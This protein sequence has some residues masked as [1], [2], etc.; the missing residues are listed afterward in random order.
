MTEEAGHTESL[1]ESLRS[2]AK[3]F[4]ALVQTR[5]EIF[6]SEVDEERTRLA[7]IMVLALTGLFCIGIAVVLFVLLIA[8][9]FW[10]N[11]R[12]LA[13]GVLAVLF[14]FSGLV[15]LL[16]LR[17]EVRQRPKFL[18]ATLAELRKDEKELEVK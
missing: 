7:R 12:L 8:V 15:A 4:I 14:A 1:L 6:A 10:E 16:V 18:A 2:L 9:L 13:I 11:N 17:S 3:T 5:I